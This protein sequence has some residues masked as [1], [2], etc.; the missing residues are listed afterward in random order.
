[1]PINHDEIYQLMNYAMGM[2]HPTIMFNKGLV[3]DD[4]TWYAPIKYAEDLDLLFRLLPYGRFANIPKYL[5][6]YRLTGNNLSLKA[7]RNT[8][9][10]ALYIREKARR[11]YD[12]RPNARARLL[13]AA[14]RL[15]TWMP[16]GLVLELYRKWRGNTYE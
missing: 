14:T 5:Y 8:L 11:E 10:A 4:F 1:L 12:Y 2:Q 7:T 16:Q 9:R 13:N 6:R 3:P 15:L